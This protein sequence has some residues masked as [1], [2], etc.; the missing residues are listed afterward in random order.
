MRGGCLAFVE[1]DE[2][3]EIGL[4]NG[5]I[6][7]IRGRKLGAPVAN[8]RL[9]DSDIGR[10]EAARSSRNLAPG[11]EGGE[12]LI[13][14]WCAHLTGALSPRKRRSKFGRRKIDKR[15]GSRT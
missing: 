7:R 5:D 9:C 11:I 6:G 4:S 12:R 3:G 8:H 13:D 2:R 15:N 10:P 1:C 14:L